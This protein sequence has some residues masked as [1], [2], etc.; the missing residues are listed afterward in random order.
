MR[1]LLVRLF[2]SLLLVWSYKQFETLKR[3]APSVYAQETTPTVD[4]NLV[5]KDSWCPDYR[6]FNKNGWSQR[7][8][9]LSSVWVKLGTEELLKDYWLNN[10]NEREV[11]WRLHNIKTEVLVCITYADTSIGKYMKSKNNIGNVGNNDRWDTVDYHSL[12]KWIDA[13]GRVLNN[14]YLWQREEI[15]QLAGST[16]PDWPNYATELTNKQRS[17]NWIVN[18]QNCLSLIN[19]TKIDGW[20]KFR[21]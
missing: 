3:P 9:T 7:C 19:E 2:I 1:E 5:N 4:D 15:R 10:Y 11:M 20:Y 21:R 16:N 8:V 12:L 18:V 13:I 17:N 14:K 6:R